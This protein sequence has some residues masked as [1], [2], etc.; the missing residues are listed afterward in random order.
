MTA[1]LLGAAAAWIAPEAEF[2]IE[3]DACRASGAQGCR[4]LVLLDAA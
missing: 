2:H 3:E 4:F 1:G